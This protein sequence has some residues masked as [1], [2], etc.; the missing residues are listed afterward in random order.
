MELVLNQQKIHNL[1]KKVVG[2]HLKNNKKNNND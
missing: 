1:K 2:K